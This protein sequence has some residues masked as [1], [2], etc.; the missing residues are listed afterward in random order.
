MAVM[1]HQ[2]ISD[3]KGVLVMDRIDREILFCCL[4][5][6]LLSFPLPFNAIT[7]GVDVQCATRSFLLDVSV[8][9]VVPM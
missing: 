1:T 3:S 4:H 8:S 7:F 5:C 6:G 2:V 9:S